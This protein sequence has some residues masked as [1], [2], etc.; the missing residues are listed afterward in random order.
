M[1]K[2]AIIALA[3]GVSDAAA[4]QTDLISVLF[5][6]A[7]EL[8]KYQAADLIADAILKAVK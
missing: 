7:A 6:P 8:R 5:T 1:L 4:A 2:T 3:Q